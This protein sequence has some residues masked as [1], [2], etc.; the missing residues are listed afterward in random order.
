MQ[1]IKIN[2]KFQVPMN[3]FIFVSFVFIELANMWTFLS[4]TFRPEH[5]TH[6]KKWYFVSC[7]E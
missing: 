4:S 6:A 3:S 7:L 2:L 5:F 1:F